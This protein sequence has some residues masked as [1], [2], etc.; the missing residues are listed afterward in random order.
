MKFRD[1]CFDDIESLYQLDKLCFHEDIAYKI[2]EFIIFLRY[3]R[4][5][6][7]VQE[8][9]GGKIIGFVMT[10]QE[11]DGEGHVITIDVHPNYRRHGI[12]TGLLH[13][14]E[15][16]LQELGV[17]IIGLEVDTNNTGA[18]KFYLC[19]DYNIVSKIHGYYSRH[20]DAYRLTKNLG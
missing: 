15:G 16:K 3:P 6:T 7:V 11:N 2:E 18:L 13:T 20:R 1:A 19:N 17:D 9:G 12:G 4:T 5:Y 8:S 10:R 14:A